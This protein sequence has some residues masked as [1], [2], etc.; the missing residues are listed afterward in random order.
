MAAGDQVGW[1]DL[2]YAATPAMCGHDMEVPDIMV[3][4]EY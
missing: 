3:N 4:L 1:K 2:T